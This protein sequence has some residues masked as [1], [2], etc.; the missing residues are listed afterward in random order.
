LY[1]KIVD[2]ALDGK[3][4]E[5][6]YYDIFGD[7]CRTIAIEHVVPIQSGVDYEKV[8]KGK[9]MSVTQFGCRFQKCKFAHSFFSHFIPTRK[10]LPI[11]LKK[12]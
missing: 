4:D 11:R 5:R 10:K 9:D 6:R 8:L 1:I 7:I 2:T 3:E 12:Y